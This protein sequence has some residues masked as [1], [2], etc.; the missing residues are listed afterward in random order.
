MGINTLGGG[1]LHISWVMYEH[2]AAGAE[3]VAGINLVRE[4]PAATTL[5]ARVRRH[6]NRDRRLADVGEAVV[7]AGAI[8]TD[9]DAR[10][11]EDFFELA[12]TESLKRREHLRLTQL[13]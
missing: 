9:L 12:F 4:L 3:V 6:L 8:A 2:R 5:L 13:Q 11:R 1:R 7:L 10:Y